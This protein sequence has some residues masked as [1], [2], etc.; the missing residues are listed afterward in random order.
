M[1]TNLFDYLE[2][3][4]ER[5]PQKLAL[6][7]GKSEVTFGQWLDFAKNIGSVIA[8]D[9][10]GQMRRPVMV[11]VDR[12][13]EPLVAFLGVV[14]S[15][16]FYVPIDSKMPPERLKYIIEV[17][18]PIAAIT[19]TDRDDELLTNSC[20][21]GWRYRFD[22]IKCAESNDLLLANLHDQLI[23]VDPVYCIFTSGS[24]GVPKGVV[25]SHRGMI[26]LGWGWI[27]KEFD[28]SD[29]DVI[30][31]QAPFYFDGS[32]KDICIC[33]MGGATMYIIPNKCF[34][35]PKL[36]GQFLNEKKITSIWWATSAVVLAANS[37]ILEVNPPK[38]VRF[39]TF[40]GESMPIKQLKQW[41]KAVPSATYVNLYGPT[42]V[43]VDSTYYVVNRDF[44]DDETLPIGNACKNKAV[45]VL[46]EE[47]KPVGIDEPG[48]LCMRGTGVALGYYNNREKTEEAFVQNPLHDFYEDKIY[49]TGDIVKYNEH[50]ELVFVSRKDFQVKHMG[51][52]I[53][54]GEIEAGV[55]AITG[56]TE[57]ACV[58]D[59]D[60][61]VIILY[62]ATSDNKER[63]IF[64][65]A[66]DRLPKY[67]QP[68]IV[69]RLDALPHNANGKIDR[70][71]LKKIYEENKENTNG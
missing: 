16:N 8:A 25:V 62:Y 68:G 24:T 37:G 43:S 19:I 39:V 55:N 59:K 57:A 29:K 15:G 14:A 6:S 69:H 67:M 40:G 38:Y 35:F 45:L 27:L 12:R 31:N 50:G 1:K 42:E 5:F 13:I 54:L 52:R 18:D 60:S 7:D 17:L 21:I 41:Q 33:L 47:N 63:D 10:K 11:F 30:G 64:N 56:V 65:L 36:L 71:A 48:E 53:E 32:V 26:D 66:K 44:T 23:D 3:T 51:Y 2:Q 28:L 34:S 61:D 20:Y 9:A 46:N 58:F 22:E 4:A 70:I 49:R